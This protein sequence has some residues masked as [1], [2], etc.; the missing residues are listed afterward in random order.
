[1]MT[2][3]TYLYDLLCHTEILLLNMLKLLKIPGFL[4]KVSQTPGFFL[5]KLSSSR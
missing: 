4:F 5:P 2:E 1:M 3:K